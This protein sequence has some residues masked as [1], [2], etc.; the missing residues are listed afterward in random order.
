VT[1]D[2]ARES[3]G[4]AIDG[5]LDPGTL[6]AFQ[7]ALEHDSVLAEEYREFMAFCAALRRGPEPGSNSPDLLPGVQQ[8]LRARSRGRFYADRF[9]ERLGAH[10][11]P[12]LL[13]AVVMLVMLALAWLGLSLL[14]G[15]FAPS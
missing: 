3:F 7:A 4:P 1:S 11:H 6:R 5:E 8:R 13:L 9:S 2:E 10:L 15:S 12:T 14:Q